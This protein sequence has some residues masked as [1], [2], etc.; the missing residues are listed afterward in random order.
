MKENRYTIQL[1]AL[2]LLLLSAL[3]LWG[4]YHAADR[5]VNARF[6]P[7]N[8]ALK[9]AK[10]DPLTIQ[11]VYRPHMVNGKMYPKE[12]WRDTGKPCG[13]NCLAQLAARSAKVGPIP[14]PTLGGLGGALLLVGG[15]TAALGFRSNPRRNVINLERDRIRITEPVASLPIVKAGGKRW[16]LMRRTL[17]GT[18]RR[19]LGNVFIFGKPGSGKSSLLKWWL[20][21]CDLL[22]F[23]VV[24]LKG[25]LWRTTAGHRETLGQVIRFDLTSMEGDALDPLEID[26]EERA[27]AIIEAF[28][29]SSTGNNSDYF[30]KRGAE[31]AFAYWKAARAAGQGPILTLVKAATIPTADMR[32]LAEG[33]VELSPQ[34]QHADLLSG[35]RTSFAALWEDPDTGGERNSTMQA[36]KGGFAQLNTP[37][38]LSTLCRTTFDPADLVD[39]RATLYISAPST[40]APYKAPI[41]ALLAGVLVAINAYV[42]HERQAEQGED[43]VLL[44]DEAGILKIPLFTETL[45]GGRSRGVSV[46]AFFQGMGQL[47]Q[48]HERGW[49]GLA[50]TS[51]H[52]VWFSG[53]DPDVDEF[54]RR[55]CGVYDVPNPDYDGQKVRRRYLEK[56]AYDEEFMVS[57]RQEQVM[58]Y[59][60]FDRKYPVFGEVLNPYADRKV[61]ALMDYS[62]ANV[63]E[64]DMLPGIPALK[65]GKLAPQPAAPK[66][67]TNTRKASPPPAATTP[68]RP[69]FDDPDEEETF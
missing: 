31:I 7:Y 34:H 1:V 53:V 62:Q 23:I 36:F 19:E 25:D 10:F 60:D 52:F 45:A 64:L 28:L 21:T 46:A 24:D 27:R 33:L 65:V 69:D 17:K 26:D 13:S 55:K 48:Y 38:I 32:G 22:N 39:G 16:G 43:I 12:F 41:E 40:Q 11:D 51:H 14:A 42:D 5:A 66:P 56:H 3:M 8:A 37:A 54:L 30:N 47:D 67:A 49:R 6:A 18:G 50:E 58:A 63:P 2:L 4:S 35:F 20:L 44:A 15:V 68:P 9:K 61:K 59:L 29:P 57:W